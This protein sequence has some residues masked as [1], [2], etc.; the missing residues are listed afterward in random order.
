MGL[1]IARVDFQGLLVIGHGVV[2]PPL[3]KECHTEIAVGFR[4]ARVDFQGLLVMYNCVVHLP[5]LKESRTKVA[6]GLRIVGIDSQRLLVLGNGAVDLPLLNESIAKIIVGCPAFR[7]LGQHIGPECFFGCINPSPLPARHPDDQQQSCTNGRL[8][9][10]FLGNNK[11]R[12][13]SQR[14]P[15]QRQ[16]SDTGQ[17]LEMIKD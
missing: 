10:Y 4:I 9:P 14:R 13:P 12:K 17:V 11:I 3:L 2:H 5:L 8:Q 7:I 6:V 1:R 15:C 16:R